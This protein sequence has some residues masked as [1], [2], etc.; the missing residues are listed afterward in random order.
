MPLNN[1]F[2]VL[3]ISADSSGSK[4]NNLVKREVI[5]AR[6]EA[7]GSSEQSELLAKASESLADPVERFKYSF[8]WLTLTDEEEKTFANCSVLSNLSNVWSD[9][10][11][12]QYESIA[13]TDDLAIRNHNNAVLQLGTAMSS[14]DKSLDDQKNLWNTAFKQ[15]LLV[16]NSSSF[17]KN[18]RQ[19]VKDIDDPRLT[20][21]ELNNWRNSIPDMILECARTNATNQLLESPNKAKNTN[22]LISEQK[23]MALH[24]V[25]IIKESPFDNNVIE[26]VLATIYEPF[27]KGIELKLDKLEKQ[28]APRDASKTILQ[29][30]FAEF[31][32]DVL[33]SLKELLT[34]GDLPG[35]AEEHAR[36]RSAKLLRQL[37]IGFHNN[38]LSDLS[39]EANE[40]AIDV[41]DSQNLLDTL[42]DEKKIV[43]KFKHI[44]NAYNLIE[45]GQYSKAVKEIEA[46]INACKSPELKSELIEVAKEIKQ[47]CANAIFNEVASA[48]RASAQSLAITGPPSRSEFDNWI[49]KLRI[50]LA[51]EGTVE[52]KAQFRE[53]ISTIETI[54]SN[55]HPVSSR[56]D[57]DIGLPSTHRVFHPHT[58]SIGS[59][60]N[61]SSESSCFV[62]TATFDSPD[63]ST[64]VELRSYRDLVL[65]N[66]PIGRL[67]INI[68]WQVGPPLAKLVR[69]LPI[70]RIILKPVLKHVCNFLVNTDRYKSRRDPSNDS[71]QNN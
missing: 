66:S 4:I 13:K 41:V 55:L 21:R 12:K 37:S 14:N 17:W 9:S 50:A 27:T 38:D 48:F 65:K 5:K 25:E 67:F 61:S 35:M 2:A 47:V 56:I 42:R 8:F 45:N 52:G 15:W 58:S 31:K 54:R 10:A 70:T 68:Y 63:N 46:K 33:P 3:K 29:K 44:G 60:R 71:P 19:R 6:L 49:R 30:T 26:R 20:E 7:T 11:N 53:L 62:A 36:D 34:V 22:V 24:W 32:K 39:Y 28:I 43:S 51:W 23:H 57:L 59:S 64:V 69:L 18:I 16:C 1:P 40:I